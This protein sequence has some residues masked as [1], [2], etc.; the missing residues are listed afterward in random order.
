MLK[1]MIQGLTSPLDTSD[2]VE[3]IKEDHKP[4]K[5]LIKVLKDGERPISE[6]RAAFETFAIELVSH[7]KPEEEVL[8]TEMQKIEACREDALEGDVE[9]GLA[10]QMIEEAKR[11]TEDKLW[12]ARVKVLAEL[13]EHHIK[14]EENDLLPGYK[15]KSTAAR[16]EELGSKFL[17]A[18]LNW[19]AKGGEDSP[20][21]ASM[22]A[23]EKTPRH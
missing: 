22:T 12:S 8:Y 5:E 6:R 7:A 1:E 3:L 11:T 4:L 23:E 19:L 13:V 10:D 16:R 2:I 14:E 20:S 18:K 15:E 21:E 17:Q 9:H